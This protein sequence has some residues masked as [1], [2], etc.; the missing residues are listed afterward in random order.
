MENNKIELSQS[1]FLR[2][3]EI[4][5]VL[6]YYF[7]HKDTGK[8]IPIGEMSNAKKDEIRT[9]IN[10]N[11]KPT[12][13]YDKYNHQ[14]R[15]LTEKELKTLTIANSLYLKHS[16][17]N[18]FC[19]DFDDETINSIEDLIKV[20]KS[21]KIFKN[22]SYFKGNTKGIHI[23]FI[24]DNVPEY[25]SELEV[26][27]NIK[28]DLIRRKNNM[29]ERADKKLYG[30][31]KLIRFDFE[32]IK[33][34][35][36]ESFFVGRTLSQK[37]TTKKTIG[38]SQKKKIVKEKM[39]K[40]VEV[41]EGYKEWEQYEITENDRKFVS[42]LRGSRFYKCDEWLHMMWVFK[43]VG[44]PFELFNE[45]SQ[46]YGNEKYISRQDCLNHWEGC[47][48][49]KINFGLLHYYA[50]LDSPEEYNKMQYSFITGE[51]REFPTIEIK[52]RYL[53]PEKIKKIDDKSDVFQ[54]EII[55]FFNSDIK[56]FNLK[57]PY[58]T[59]KTQM[60]K[61]IIDTFN[62]SKILWLSYRKTL[63]NDILG[64]FATTYNFKDYQKKEFN[65]DRLIIQLES[66]LKLESSMDWIDDIIEYPSYDLVIIDEIESILKQFNSPTFKGNS[67]E[68]FNFVENIIIN[69]K[70]L[71]TMDGDIGNRTYNFTS[72]F[73]DMINIVNN[74]KINRRVFR[75]SENE[76]NYYENIKLDLIFDKKIVIVSMSATACETYSYKI[77]KDFKDK[78]ILVYTGNSADK[79]KEDFKDVLNVW[80]KC[81]V[82]IY[83]PT[84]ES[85]VNFDKEHFD[86]MY[87][88]LSDST[89]SRQF[90]Q[91]LARVRKIK[92]N[93]ILLLNQTFKSIAN[94]NKFF[95]FDEV[96]TSIC[97]LDNIKLS[98]EA[99]CINGKMCRSLN[100]KLKPY[101]INYIYNKL[102]EINNN[103]YYFLSMFINLCF[104]KG[105]Q[106]MFLNDKPTEKELINKKKKENNDEFNIKI[107]NAQLLL[108]TEDIT[109]KRYNELLEKQK[110]DD[111][112][113]DEKYKIKKH[114]LKLALGVDK[115][116][117]TI[118]KKFNVNSIKNYIGLIDENNIKDNDD[119]QTLELKD[120]SRLLN[121]LIK[122]L[123]FTNIFDN[124]KIDKNLFIKNMNKVLNSNEVF[125]D[126]KNT[127]IRFELNKSKA[128][129]STKKFLGFINSLLKNYHIKIS[130]IQ[131]RE[132][133]DSDKE[134]A[135]IIEHLDYINEF[136]EYR[137][138][139][140]LKLIDRNNIR[141]KSTTEIYKSY[142]DW[143]LVKKIEERLIKK[144]EEK[145][146]ILENL[147][148]F[149]M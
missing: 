111:A 55:K 48:T 43:S 143:E 82:L 49:S 17:E 72:S 41:N 12:S 137:I 128:I 59:G 117:E 46:K 22:C 14:Y 11:K 2:N 7:I 77:R 91:M 69:S 65:A 93:D 5:S 80:D 115:L 105:H 126:I 131:I 87:G 85:G 75:I 62:P 42:L 25:K 104:N 127:Q 28:G 140:G 67:K 120:K 83:S 58:D 66:I 68:C 110:K 52:Q 134:S 121:Q 76:D 123:G 15:P 60:I 21:F 31:S 45:L 20:N 147:K 113:E 73:G 1:E 81:D 26:F 99:V 74:I 78:K 94:I 122:D 64:N 51:E 88:I 119:N 92:S 102:E 106:V 118:I 101:D 61:R 27:N 10:I 9:T 38:L 44:L 125:T 50:K 90:L 3:N 18:I 53:L 34:L 124:K 148:A 135:Y 71:L 70:K 142:V 109:N 116:D 54:N 89:T 114:T 100:N 98:S 19:A 84:C 86:V 30:S 149:D 35:L 144:E 37:N 112:T 57:S 13:F 23:Y 132:K 63:T 145:A 136:L 103:K 141:E 96:K 6:I 97:L 40:V 107:T 16:N 108:D 95:T 146:V 29:W 133:W 56:T 129:N 39:G 79:S 8:K 4:P 24:V 32:T 139:K 138:I 33:P 36:N 130:R 47:K